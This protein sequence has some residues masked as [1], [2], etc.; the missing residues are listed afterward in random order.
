MM[1]LIDERWRQ[2]DKLFQ[3]VIEIEPAG[4]A[5]YLDDACAGDASLREEVCSLLT[6]DSQEWDFIEKPALESAAVLLADDQPRFSAG[7]QVG[8]Y[9]IESFIGSGGMGEVYRAK[10]PILGRTVALKLLPFEYTRD[11][12]RL[13]RFQREA[14]TFSS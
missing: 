8:H 2:V 5:A 10:D 11:Q 1:T 14:Q 4:R 6:R 3:A 9:E 13:D 7:Q 12:A